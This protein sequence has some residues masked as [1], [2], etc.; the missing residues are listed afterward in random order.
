MHTLNVPEIAEAV[1]INPIYLNRLFKSSTGSTI[2]NYLSQYRCEHARAMLENTQATVN[3]I[4]D[5]C[6][7]SEVRSFIRFFKKYYGQTP[8]EYRKR[9]KQ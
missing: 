1:N 4:S 9:A 6:G 5:A 7:F 3:E 2:S 8:T